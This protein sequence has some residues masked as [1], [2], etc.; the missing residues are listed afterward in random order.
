M[1]TLTIQQNGG[2]KEGGDTWILE[3][4]DF[5]Y[6]LYSESDDGERELTDQ[7]QGGRAYEA[8]VR[9][10]PTIAASLIAQLIAKEAAQ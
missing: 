10:F 5:S 9:R 2:S 4:G 3:Y 8:L 1:K 6:K 7:A